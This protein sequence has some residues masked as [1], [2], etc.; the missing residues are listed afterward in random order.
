MDRDR[1]LMRRVRAPLRLLPDGDW[2]TITQIHLWGGFVCICAGL[3]GEGMVCGW[4]RLGRW[5][6]R[7]FGCDGH[8]HVCRAATGKSV[9]VLEWAHAVECY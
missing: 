5:P 6:P 2:L 1:G 8:P 4:L 9:Y 7:R 3:Y